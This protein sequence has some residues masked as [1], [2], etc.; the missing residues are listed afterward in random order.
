MTGAGSMARADLHSPS[1]GVSPAVRAGLVL[2]IGLLAAAVVVLAA[3]LVL[4][5]LLTVP[6]L[7]ATD[8]AWLEG[9]FTTA[10]FGVLALVAVLGLRLGG[11]WPGLGR[12]AVLGAPL[13]LG[14]GV[15]GVGLSL[16][17]SSVAGTLVT[18]AAGG[19]GPGALLGGTLAVLLQTGA[20]EFYFR[21]WIQ[22]VVITGWGRWPGLAA[23]A[24][25]FAAVHFVS[26]AGE[27]LAFLNLALAGVWLGL[28][29][30]RSGGLALPL[31][32]HFGW[33]WAEELLL[34]ASPN[35]GV[36][37]FGAVLD[38]DLAG[39][40][41]WGGTA[42]ALNASLAASFVLAAVVAVTI[43]WPE[44]LGRRET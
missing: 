17:L 32:G 15:A 4:N 35:P 3:P 44:G 36:G 1:R 6:A 38:Y 8:P 20:E 21:G 40:P 7:A 27:P 33:N 13:G 9:L 5:L 22:P 34:G 12:H 19:I 29:A 23:T 26:A 10:V 24:I 16:G 11:T 18:G 14:L 2:G 25:G 42:E 39:N 43:A 28:L 30:Q 31:A 41:L 37:N